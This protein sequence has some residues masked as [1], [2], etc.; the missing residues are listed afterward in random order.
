MY[1]KARATEMWRDEACAHFNNITLP[2]VITNTLKRMSVL[3]FYDFV[4]K[5]PFINTIWQLSVTEKISCL[6]WSKRRGSVM[7]RHNP[8]LKGI[9]P[10]MDNRGLTKFAWTIHKQPVKTLCR[11]A[12]DSA[13]CA[14]IRHGHQKPSHPGRLPLL[15]YVL[16]IGSYNGGLK[17][18]LSSPSSS[19]TAQE[20]LSA[21]SFG[22]SVQKL[23]KFII[24]TIYPLRL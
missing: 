1:N 18:Q 4:F 21:S 15:M 3:S 8:I 5:L 11:N 10:L 9:S 16:L 14:A 6:P 12:S 24:I 20:K 7:N 22:R 23:E 19:A 2:F 17:S 13:G